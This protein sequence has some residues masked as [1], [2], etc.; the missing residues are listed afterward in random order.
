MLETGHN[1]RD[2]RDTLAVKGLRPYLI[3]KPLSFP[4]SFSTRLACFDTESYNARIYANENDILYAYSFP[5]Y[6]WAISTSATVSRAT[7]AC[8]SASPTSSIT[9]APP[10]AVVC[11][12][13]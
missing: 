7:S 5:V 4:V 6:Y 13:F 1:R 8:G 9:T 12:R 2:G 10:W 11:M 3:F